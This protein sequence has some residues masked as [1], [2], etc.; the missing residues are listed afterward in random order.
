[1]FDENA[2]ADVS[3]DNGLTAKTFGEVELRV[4]LPAATKLGQGNVFTGVCDSVHRGGCL[5]QCMLGYHPA[6]LQQSWHPPPQEADCGIQS[7]SGRYASYWNA[8]LVEIQLLWTKFQF[9]TILFESKN[10][11]CFDVI[12]KLKSWYTL[13]RLLRLSCM[14][15]KSLKK[16]TSIYYWPKRSF[17]QGN[18]FTRVCH[19]VHRGGSIWPGT[20]QDQVHP[21]PGTRQ[22]HTPQTRYTPPPLQKQQTPEYSQRSAGTH[23]TG[24]HSCINEYWRLC[25]NIWRG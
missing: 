21:P 5:P 6:P 3:C 11:R 7:T 15:K 19:S 18:I 9:I 14:R 4:F 22:V 13:E 2:N 12:W 8:F 16:A 20:P 10:C 23:P 1:M 24:M 17:G 25:S